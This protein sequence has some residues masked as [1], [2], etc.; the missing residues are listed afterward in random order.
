MAGYKLD[1]ERD[2]YGF[3]VGM[4]SRFDDMVFNDYGYDELIEIWRKACTHAP[5]YLLHANVCC[6]CDRTTPPP[7]LRRSFCS[8]TRAM[9]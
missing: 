2:L 3:N 7:F 6:A 5:A 1:V 4:K 8:A 9:A